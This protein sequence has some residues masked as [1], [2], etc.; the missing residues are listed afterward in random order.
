[1][2]DAESI[3]SE[4]SHSSD[5]D[6]EDDIDDSFN[7]EEQREDDNEGSCNS[8]EG[9]ENDLEDS[10]NDE[11]ENEDNAIDTFEED[12]DEVDGEIAEM[13]QKL[14]SG[15]TKCNSRWFKKGKSKK[16]IRDSNDVQDVLDCSDIVSSK[17][18][19]DD[20]DELTKT[21]R[22]RKVKRVLTEQENV[23]QDHMA[24]RGHLSPKV[25]SSVAQ[26]S[27]SFP[28]RGNWAEKKISYEAKN[29]LTPCSDNLSSVNK[30]RTVS[31]KDSVEPYPGADVTSATFNISGT[32]KPMLRVLDISSIQEDSFSNGNLSF[33][34]IS[35]PGKKTY[36]KPK[37][38]EV[39]QKSFGD[40]YAIDDAVCDA[41]RMSSN[42]DLKSVE[43]CPPKTQLGQKIQNHLKPCLDP[44]G[45][46]E[47]TDI[48][49]IKS[50][51]IQREEHKS[52]SSALSVSSC[53]T[54]ISDAVFKSPHG[55]TV[56]RVR[57]KQLSSNV[58]VTSQETCLSGTKNTHKP[59]SP[60]K[61]SEASLCA[62]QMWKKC[63]SIISSLSVSS[64]GNLQ[65]SLKHCAKGGTK[66]RS[67]FD[68]NQ[69]NNRGSSQAERLETNAG[70][71]IAEKIHNGMSFT[72]N[73]ES[74]RPWSKAYELALESPSKRKGKPCSYFEKSPVSSFNKE[75]ENCPQTHWGPSSPSCSGKLNVSLTSSFQNM[76]LQPS[77]LCDRNHKVIK[78]NGLKQTKTITSNS[79]FALQNGLQDVDLKGF[80]CK[81]SKRSD[82]TF[83]QLIPSLP[84]KLMNSPMF[85]PEFPAWTER[86]RRN[87]LK[88]AGFDMQKW[89]SSETLKP[90]LNDISSMKRKI[91]TSFT[92][93]YCSQTSPSLDEIGQNTGTFPLTIA[94]SKSKNIESAFH[95]NHAN[96]SS[97]NEETC[98]QGSHLDLK[99]RQFCPQAASAF[100][101]GSKFSDY[102]ELSFKG[103]HS[104]DS[105]QQSS[106]WKKPVTSSD[107]KY[108]KPKPRPQPEVGRTNP[109]LLSNQRDRLP[110]SLV[111]PQAM[112]PRVLFNMDNSHVLRWL[113]ASSKH[114]NLPETAQYPS[115][116]FLSENKLFS[117]G[118][119]RLQGTDKKLP[120]KSLAAQ[121]SPVVSCHEKKDVGVQVQLDIGQNPCLPRPSMSLMFANS[122]CQQLNKTPC[123]Y[124]SS[125]HI[126]CWPSVPEPRESSKQSF[127]SRP[128]PSQHHICLGNINLNGTQSCFNKPISTTT[129]KSFSVGQN[130]LN[131]RAMAVWREIQ[132][133]KSVAE[134][135]PSDFSVIGTNTSFSPST[136]SND[137]QSRG[138]DDEGNQF[139]DDEEAV[140]ETLLDEESMAQREHNLN[141]L[142]WGNHE[143]KSF[144]ESQNAR[145]KFQAE[146]QKQNSNRL[147][148]PVKAQ[149]TCQN[150][151][152]PL[153]Y[154]NQFSPD[155]PARRDSDMTTYQYEQQLI[156]S[157]PSYK[158]MLKCFK[159]RR[160]QQ[161]VRTASASPTKVKPICPL[162]LVD[163]AVKERP[164]K[165]RKITKLSP[166]KTKLNS[167]EH[168]R[169]VSQ[170]PC[171]SR[172]KLIKKKECASFKSPKSQFTATNVSC[173][174][175]P[176]F[177]H[178]T[179]SRVSTPVKKTLYM[180]ELDLDETIST[181]ISPTAIKENHDDSVLNRTPTPHDYIQCLGSS[182]SDSED[183]V[184]LL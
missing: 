44:C 7:S 121:P 102:R 48:A 46:G 129:Q 23:I 160:N 80:R 111:T 69:N 131:K 124:H 158:N 3:G 98:H 162:W 19:Q 56:R 163:D 14:P 149:K 41:K 101:F 161:Q 123:L 51:A 125:K 8:E 108:S 55:I 126:S 90:R 110:T 10:C 45:T 136:I 72:S 24:S 50:S 79:L 139:A 127:S 138:E 63:D 15:E 75:L 113:E 70:N 137:E 112:K 168:N 22:V 47:K 114:Y 60:A 122:P 105:L 153:S 169:V 182:E 133:E 33:V 49:V 39:K 65:R 34:S 21:K 107:L 13:E 96:D 16:D 25:S 166:A 71:E 4:N 134:L 155:N 130:S 38:T 167:T 93:G 170:R 28:T 164:S 61:S 35:S 174:N 88:T 67:E 156:A 77:Q 81:D 144:V 119:K 57:P 150:V 184:S 143:S 183:E 120:I 181:I 172:S 157:T 140:N 154:I 12:K 30:L 62:T 115:S 29:S 95:L 180:P 82:S 145:I 173:N 92:S 91:P 177:S 52:V 151:M 6:D 97:K 132:A 142:F 86:N 42:A 141:K 36:F 20:F 128:V 146:L 94:L 83:T 5:D 106:V 100:V 176:S 87:R 2:S 85:S 159:P 68:A 18:F 9:N 11:K 58:S 165:C 78:G 64:A 27:V 54:S 116:N 99:T 135:S 179:K 76:D 66:D 89:C 32:G 152:F 175:S 37:T 178:T 148:S 117:S 43:H 84:S 74:E 53:P 31:K 104:M 59:V 1:M 171:K 147:K 118:A 109:F 26:G 73:E 17:D 103:I 40:T